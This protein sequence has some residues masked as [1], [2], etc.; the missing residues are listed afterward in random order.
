MSA[1][2]FSSFPP[3]FSSFPDPDAGPAKNKKRRE[4]TSPKER[5]RVTE[6]HNHG[7][8]KNRHKPRLRKEVKKDEE[9][10]AQPTEPH[11]PDVLNR[12]FYSD[13]KGDPMNI[14]Y[15][16]LHSGDIPKYHL[17]GGGRNILGLPKAFVAL[18]RF[19][20]GVEVGLSHQRK[21]S[22]LTDS[23]SRA[24][25][26]K[27]PSR[28][29]FSSN[30]DGKYQEVDGFIRLPSRR[31]RGVGEESYRSIT[32]ENHDNSDS[33]SS[34]ASEADVSSDEGSDEPTLT[35]HQE[36][37]KRLEQELTV[38]P[39]AVD[40]WFSLLSQ[41][42][43]CEIT[44]S[45]LSRALS[46]AP[47]NATNKVLRLAFLK[48]GEEIW[49]ESKLR[50]E[51]EETLKVGGI[52]VQMEW[53]EWKIRTMNHGIDE[54]VEAAARALESLGVDEDSE[55][56]KIRI[57]W[58]YSERAM[59]MFQAEAELI[60]NPP[61]NISKM[62]LQA[63]LNELEDFWDSEVSR[64]GE[65]GAR[66]WASWY[67]SKTDQNSVPT[68]QASQPSTIP[69]LDPYRQWASQE[70]Q[71]DRKMFLPLRSDSDTSDPYSTVLFA[72]IRS[73]MLNIKYRRAKHAFRMAWL[74]FLGLHVPG[75]SLA[76]SHELDWDDRWNL[77][78]LTSPYYLNAIFP[79][80]ANQNALLTDAVAGVVIGRERQHATSFGPVRCWGKDVSGPL[81]LSSTDP[82]KPLHKGIWTMEDVLNT[83]ENITRKLFTAL[84]ID[85]DDSEWD[86]L[87]LAFETAI[88]P[89]SAIKLSKSLLSVNR[90][91]LA[92]WNAHAQLERMRGRLGDARKVYQTLLIANKHDT[93][94]KQAGFL[95][96][97][98]AEM[99]WLAGG[100]QTA[101]N[102]ILKSV[103]MEGPDSGITILRAKRSLE[104]EADAAKASTGWKEHEGWVRLRAL[105]ELLTGHGPVAALEVFDKYLSFDYGGPSR[106]SLTTASL[107]MIYC[108][109]VV[110]KKPMPPSI[111][112]ERAHPAFEDYPNNSIILGVLLEA[113][114]GQ[115]VWGRVRAML[116]GNDGKVKDVARRI[117]EVWVAGWE[118]GRWLSE[119]ER[120]RASS[121]IWRIYIEFEIRVHELQRA[122]KLL[123]RAIGECPLVKELYLLAFGPLRSVFHAHELNGLADTMAERGIRLRQGLDEVVEG[124][125]L[126]DEEAREGNDESEDE[127]EHNA[128][129]LRR[130]MPY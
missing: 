4:E 12:F 9:R 119:H 111:L 27:P 36:T 120:T 130:L 108:H 89:K 123:F 31:G 42:F 28:R 40:T 124:M 115:G 34:S 83:D 82:G 76:G 58:R 11:V 57:F 125:G 85:H 126:V 54:V 69:D 91:S 101:L 109:G 121:V 122:K 78:H 37:L 93:S 52:E 43:R 48:A 63:Q 129:E 81:D 71:A 38:K 113:E 35:T 65:D 29:L 56:A 26:S 62:A 6:G 18:R 66:G 86:T 46:A 32:R 70:L 64:L 39:D 98:W 33:S 49:H 45:I 44:V 88:S 60:F 114:R 90:D 59:A 116:G 15:G 5:G 103:G 99:E 73:M 30:D 50:S 20:K 77:G 117:E 79:S 84:R 74:S 1:P 106:E 7:R 72:D 102:I 55:V 19:G 118:K 47:Q 107:M 23:S 10:P 96:W 2:S 112:R 16:G 110:L 3:S 17:V 41:T 61:A 67:S 21:V 87:A 97:S 24:L 22:S 13:R 51:W 8:D 53:L 104:D 75:L 127:I 100:D 95:W 92:L 105:L 80:D 14:Q 68:S 25:L 94:Q 128:R